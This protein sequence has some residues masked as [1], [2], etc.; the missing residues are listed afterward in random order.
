L[1]SPEQ[2]YGRGRIGRGEV[3]MEKL[4]GAELYETVSDGVD[5]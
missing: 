2:A 1:S 4:L 5:N 3:G